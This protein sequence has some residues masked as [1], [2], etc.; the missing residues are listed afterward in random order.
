MTKA[1]EM[2]LKVHKPLKLSPPGGSVSPA[3]VLPF[4]LKPGVDD[5]SILW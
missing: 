5:G 2:E 1:G 3:G 4:N